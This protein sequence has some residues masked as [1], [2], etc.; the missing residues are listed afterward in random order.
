MIFGGYGIS[1]WINLK[2]FTPPLAVIGSN[3]ACFNNIQSHQNTPPL[4]RLG[5]LSQNRTMYKKRILL[6]YIG[7]TPY[8]ELEDI[9]VKLDYFNP[10]GS[11]KDRIAKHI[12]LE[13][14]KTGKLKDGMEVVEATSGNSGIAFSMVCAI[15]GYKMNVIMPEGLTS[16]RIEYL[17][18]YNANI[19]MTPKEDG[20]LGSVQ[21]EE[22]MSKNPKYFCVR[23]FENELNVEAHRQTLGKEIIDEYPKEI[24]AFV[25]GVG[26]GGTLMGVGSLIKKKFPNAK[27]F[28]V[29]PS[30]SPVLKGGLHHEHKIEG[31]GDGFVPDIYKRYKGIVDGVV[32][33]SSED[34]IFETKKLAAK[35]I[36][37]GIS[38]GANF[39]AAKQLKNKFKNIV[40]VFPDRGERYFSMGIYEKEVIKTGKIVH[41]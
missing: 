17:K 34:S 28:A 20:V 24:H 10:S 36:L 25:A 9:F 38:S 37:G 19:I 35:G 33:I 31:I 2:N 3:P 7:S 23:Q 21:K 41:F 29:E 5:I 16:E 22:E 8:I 14:I 11:T 12:L 27:I 39:L 6:D 4:G 30:E 32:Q 40:T 15:L 1:D 26:T 13:A 18:A